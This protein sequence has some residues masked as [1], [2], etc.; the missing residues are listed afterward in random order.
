MSQR[1][2]AD[3]IHKSQNLV[4]TIESGKFDPG[5]FVVKRIVDTLDLDFDIV[6]KIL[7]GESTTITTKPK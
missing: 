1:E 4:H 7:D 2:L 5:I 3:A 6:L